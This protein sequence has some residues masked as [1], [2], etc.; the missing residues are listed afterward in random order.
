MGRITLLNALRA[1]KVKMSNKWL[2]EMKDKMQR[3]GEGRNSK[4]SRKKWT[5]I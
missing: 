1:S 3:P 4:E 2:R 5:E